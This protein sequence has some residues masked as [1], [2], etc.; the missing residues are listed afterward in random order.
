MSVEHVLVFVRIK[1]PL[2]GRCIA[3]KFSTG[4]VVGV[5]KGVEK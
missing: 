5:V 3:D 4:W 2:K 1:A